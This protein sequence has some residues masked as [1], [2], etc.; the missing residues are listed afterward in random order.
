[1]L[2][3]LDAEPVPDPNGLRVVVTKAGK[4][5][6]KVRGFAVELEINIE[7]LTINFWAAKFLVFILFCLSV[8]FVPPFC[9]FLG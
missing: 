7:P 9:T 5:G 8:C 4:S 3:G 6:E 2:A 1:M